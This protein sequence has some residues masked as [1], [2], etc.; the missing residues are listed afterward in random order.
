[1]FGPGKRERSLCL[2][3]TGPSFIR[4]SMSTHMLRRIQHVMKVRHAFRGC[5]SS[6]LL[7]QRQRPLILQTLVPLSRAPCSGTCYKCTRLGQVRRF[8]DTVSSTILKGGRQRHLAKGEVC[9]SLQFDGRVR[10]RF[11]H[12]LF[13]HTVFL[14]LYTRASCILPGQPTLTSRNFPWPPTTACQT[15]L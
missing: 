11:L 5:S 1:M 8:L 4:S 14:N 15:I 12:S 2:G 13:F 6:R 10:S 3:L 7:R 9:H